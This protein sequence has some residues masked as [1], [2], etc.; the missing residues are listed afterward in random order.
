M[1]IN[2]Y[3][4]KKEIKNFPNLDEEMNKYYDFVI[5]DIAPKKTISPRGY[6]NYR[7]GRRDTFYYISWL[8]DNNPTSVV[9]IGCGENIFK[10]WFPNIYGVDIHATSQFNRPDEVMELDLFFSTY[11]NKFDC[12][13]AINSIHFGDFDHVVQNINSCMDLIKNGGRFLFTINYAILHRHSVKEQQYYSMY[14]QKY[15]DFIMNSNY[16]LILFDYL[17]ARGTIRN[18]SFINGDVRFVLEKQ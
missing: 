4:P 14:D 18:K 9:D 6:E 8:Y 10:N 3:A 5:T 7:V 1:L 17:T 2:E 13:M 12:G 16:K 11:K 15:Y